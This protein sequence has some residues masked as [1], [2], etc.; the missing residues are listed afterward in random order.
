MKR[1]PNLSTLADDPW[2]AAY[3]PILRARAERTR[4]LARRLKGRLDRLK[5]FAAAHT[6]YG[7]HPHVDGWVFREHAP[8]ATAVWLTGDC[9]DWRREP[10]YALS[11]ISEAGDW[12]VILPPDAL[13]HGQHYQLELEWPGGG[14][15]RLPAYAR[16]VVQ[17]PATERFSAQVWSPPNPH[18]WLHPRFRMPDRY[19]IIYECH[20]GMAQ[21]E[22]AVGTYDAFREQVL[23][24]VA[25]AG[26]NTL[27][28]MA[29]M[30]HPYY[31]SFGYQVSSFFACSS[32]FGTPESLKALIDAAHGMGI[33]VIMDLIHSHAVLNTREGIARLDGTPY[34]YCHDGPRGR[35]PVWDSACFD[36]GRLATLHFLLSNC[37]Y[38]LDEFHFD[39]F[40]FDGVTSM[41]YHHHG[42]GVDFVGY[43]QYFDDSVDEDAHTYLALANTVIHAVRPDAI[44]IAEDVSGMPGLGAPPRE[45][46]AGFDFRLAMGITETWGRL[47]REIPDPDW[48]LPWLWHELTNRRADEQTISYVECHD[49]AMVGGKTLFFELTGSALYTGMHKGSGN[50]VVERAV[51]LHK[52]ARLLTLGTA[53][54]GY[55]NFMGNEFGH[56]EWIDFP[57]EGNGFSFAHAR[58]Q[59]HLRDDPGLQFGWLADFDE[60][61]ITA[62]S[63]TSGVL[64]APVRTLCVDTGAKI[65]VF[66][67]GRFFVAVNLHATQSYADWE[68]RVPPGVYALVLNTDSPAF[69]GQGRIVDGQIFRTLSD[70]VG[71]ERVEK[72]RV[73]LPARTALVVERRADDAG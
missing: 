50:L 37:R 9:N 62:F 47:A 3:R 20:V 51:A 63:G 15:E 70:V 8:H 27:Q 30:E 22:A 43:G 1:D 25:Q 42:L 45:G 6:F 31:G 40:R 38:W 34:L 14:G 67:R 11:R 26:Y 4:A 69:G 5:D 57:R 39:G 32:R 10:A 55:L 59:W 68:I 61:M 29:V 56:P 46:G 44:T 65:I 17:D 7:L 2:L 28:L 23:P 35:H 58:R 41:L 73:Y 36:Y 60:A 21:D 19:P 53:A 48:Q 49:Q 16:R 52:I 33:A 12:E 64:D 71:C 24:R 66:A 72:L 13:R 54:H 18:V